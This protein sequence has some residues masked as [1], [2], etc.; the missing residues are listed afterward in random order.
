M[1]IN[2]S[3]VDEEQ[4][5][6]LKSATI[7]R[8]FSYLKNYKRQVA[9]VLVVLAVTIAISTV[10]PLLLE[11]AIDVNIAQKDWRGLVALCVFMVVINLVYAAGVRLRMLLMARI[12]NNILLEIRDELYTH[13]QTLSFSFFDTR[14]AGKIL[15]RIIGDVNSLK[16][17]LNDGVT[18]L[19][20]NILTII[21]IL[22]IMMIKNIWL[23]LSAI[24][25]L[26]L[27]AVGMY[28]IQIVAHKR[29]QTFRKKS[30]NVTA[31]IHEDF[32]GIRII[33]SFTAE[34]E[35][36]GEFD[37][38]LLEHQNS[39]IHAVRL[40]D[41]FSAVIEVTWGIGTFLLYFIGIS[42]LGVDA[43]PIG[44]FTAF[45]MYLTMFWD[46]IQNLAGFYNKLIT[47][48]SAAERI[49]EILDTP[50][51]VADKPGVT[52]LPPIKGEVTFDHVS[53]AYSDDPDTL[54]LKDVSFTAAP[55]ETIALV[56]PTGA[57]KTTIVNLIS[58]FYNITSGTVRVDGHS[59]TDVSINSLRAQMGVMTQDNF[60]FS[61][62]IRDN[63][64]YGKLDATEEEII[65]AAKDVH[66]HEFIIELPDGYDLTVTAPEQ[67]AG[68]TAHLRDGA[69]TLAFDDIILPAGD[70][71]GA[72]L[73]PLTALPYVVQAIRSGYVDLTWTEDGLQVVQL[74]T[75][76]HTAVRLYLDGTVPQCAE[77]SVDDT[78]CL[79]CTM[80]N[81]NLEQGSMN[82]ESQDP[83]LGRDQSQ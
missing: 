57:G 79:R 12:T 8:L 54:V 47:N 32:S 14:P 72:G 23:S 77:L 48:L 29:W 37:R 30:S 25:V 21:A 69:S 11:Y 9:V 63:I 3:K 45:A 46:P 60:L 64:A 61:G 2:S 17:V 75:D 50:A 35:S 81:W 4:K 7:R 33:K 56:G 78:L 15:A 59:L 80:E 1:A 28:F 13:I 22:V 51:E 36:Q 44:T 73:T 27:I 65:A 41:G 67:A 31:Y 52:E 74:I 76:D 53:F 66:Y 42:V 83:N 55:G 82:D 19:I 20:P 34:Q 43:V 49:F 10:N 24:L 26:P 70:L 71:N 58:R 18:K 16:D 5:E 62:T 6:V 38:L 68:V 39:F 40:A